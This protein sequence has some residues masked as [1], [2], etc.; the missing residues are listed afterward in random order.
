MSRAK[1]TYVPDPRTWDA[2]QVASSLGRG[3][4]WFKEHQG[5]LEANGFPLYDG[6]LGGWD[7]KAIEAWRDKRSGLATAAKDDAAWMEALHNG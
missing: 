6:L 3:P 1:P 4:E 7:G 2:Y 5:E